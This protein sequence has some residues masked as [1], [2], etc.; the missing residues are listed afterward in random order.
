MCGRANDVI[1][2]PHPTPPHPTPPPHPPQPTPRTPPTHPPTRHTEY[3]TRPEKLRHAPQ[4]A[5]KIGKL[6]GVASSDVGINKGIG[7]LAALEL[8]TSFFIIRNSQGR[9][10]ET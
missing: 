6:G 4:A 1:L 3:M 8:S 5:R 9:M 10:L 2:P 7:W